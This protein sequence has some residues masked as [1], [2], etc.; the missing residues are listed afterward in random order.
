MSDARKQEAQ[1][2]RTP[3]A[4]VTAPT[5]GPAPAPPPPTAPEAVL[6]LQ[7]RAGN[8]AT[9][10]A[11][12]QSSG[13][14]EARIPAGGR[15]LAAPLRDEMER[16]F[17]EDFGAVRI[18]TGEHAARSAASLSAKAYTHGR[19]VVFSAGRFAPQS[20]AGKQLIA[21]E[22]AHVVQQGRAHAGDRQ[23]R[24]QAERSADVAAAGISC[25]AATVAVQGSAP[26]AV[27]R[28]PEDDPARRTLTQRLFNML[29]G[30]AQAAVASAV[31]I[32]EVVEARLAPATKAK[33]EK[34][35]T[36]IEKAGQIS[37]QSTSDPDQAVWLGTPPLDVRLKQAA[38]QKRRDADA[39]QDNPL[40]MGDPPR[41]PGA[42]GR[43]DLPAGDLFAPEPAPTPFEL[44][45]RSG[46]KFLHSFEALAPD[47]DP[48]K[49]VWVGRRTPTRDELKHIQ[50]RP[51]DTMPPSTSIGIP[52]ESRV[53]VTIG[54]DDVMPIRDFN[55]GELKGYRLVR[56]DTTFELDRNGQPLGIFG[57][58]RP[59]EQPAIDP[60][61]VLMLG[62]DVGPIVAKGLTSGAK[63]IAGRVAKT[64]V[65]GT[66]DAATEE[67]AS[68]AAKKATQQAG[69]GALDAA[70][71]GAPAVRYEG[72]ELPLIV[73]DAVPRGIQGRKPRGF[74][75]GRA[76]PGRNVKPG[77][78]ED[79][80]ATS[81]D[82]ARRPR[83]RSVTRSQQLE[84]IDLATKA[85]RED[86]TP[87]MNDALK[88]ASDADHPLHQLV[89]PQ[90]GGAFDWHTTERVTKKGRVEKGRY[91]GGEDHP[92]VQ[93]GH[94]EAY[95]GGGKQE[96]MI[97]DADLNQLTGQAIESR[98]SLSIKE[99][100]LVTKPD[101]S[102]GIWVEKASLEQWERLGAVPSGTTARAASH[103]SSLADV[104]R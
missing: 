46:Q 10:H 85:P 29:P 28:Q 64:A 55:T 60:I 11:L 5:I 4:G 83:S 22:L 68:L 25:G 81:L 33:V 6:Q 21:H 44:Q 48:T 65:R 51:A 2:T 42:A 35:V 49:A 18:H 57:T 36:A 39:K 19:D 23:D 97:E 50:L 24:A 34:V 72:G 93:A 98:G 66:S 61:D 43:Q 12:R 75:T 90:E 32:A 67:A 13:S 14:V 38:A 16:R 47:I 63:S 74:D 31:P 92:V 58:E 45:L 76:T 88:H 52:G 53:D 17:G 95:A 73:D 89:G 15:P 79:L 59:L 27:A 100:V 41:R 77:T 9:S 70:K 40:G 56:G 87:F 82:S 103:P 84:G 20:R 30:R 62:V 1:P 3:Q 91:H 69:S 7:R 99:R 86:P 78:L 80:E 37:A 71:A 96:F 8:R 102:G 104:S 54:G 101:G 26:V 94:K